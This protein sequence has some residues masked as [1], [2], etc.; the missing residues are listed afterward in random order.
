MTSPLFVEA[1]TRWD[2]IAVAWLFGL[3]TVFGLLVRRS[4]R[5]ASSTG[6]IMAR[7]RH[8]WFEQIARREVRIMD[9]NIVN[10]LRAGVAFFISATLLALGGAIAL[11]GQSEQVALV[12]QDL[13]GGFASP[14]GPWAVAAPRAAWIVKL[15]LV[16]GMLG[17]AFL[18]FVWSHRLMGY[19]AVLIGA[20][21]Q[22]KSDPDAL[23]I[24][25][26]A[27]RLNILATRHFN[28]GLVAVYFTL[29]ALAWLAGPAALIAAATVTFAILVR[30]EFFSRARR[31]L[32]E[33]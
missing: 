8:R 22:N 5:D 14:R 1:F 4:R 26:K 27:A 32:L 9:T 31:A 30:R 20:I 25:R 2:G 6:E 10:G 3:W 18:H 24:A 17:V 13:T 15:L 33:D 12:A 7:Y 16:S 23:G 11:I 29:A 28:R 21:P 19:V